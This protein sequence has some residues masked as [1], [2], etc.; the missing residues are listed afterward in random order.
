MTTPSDSWC[1]PSWPTPRGPRL[2]RGSTIRVRLAVSVR[3]W[4][5]GMT[6]LSASEESTT[7]VTLPAALPGGVRWRWACASL[8]LL[9]A[10]LWALQIQTSYARWGLFRWIGVDWGSQFAQARV[11]LSGPPEAIYNLAAL[12]QAKQVLAAY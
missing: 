7:A 12:R 3:L 5:V 2:N 4:C 9:T 8:A 11:F 6:A 10:V 1:A